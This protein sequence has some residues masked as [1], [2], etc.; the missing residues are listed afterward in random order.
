MRV[1]I[2]G[3]NFS[4]ELTGIGKYTGELA[5][6]LAQHGHE[7][8][9]ITSP[10]YYPYWSVQR[11]YRA[12][13]YKREHLDGV[14]V[15]RCPLWVPGRPTAIKRIIHLA[16]FAL[17]SL[18]V[19]LSQVTWR[20]HIVFT[21]EPTLFGVT[22]AALVAKLTGAKS[23][24]HV[25]DLEVDA[26]MGLGIV[27]GGTA[28]RVMSKSERWLMNRFDRVSSIS[29][30]MLTRLQ[31][32]GVAAD[33]L[34]EFL[35]WVDT[36]DI[37]PVDSADLLRAEWGIDKAARVVLYSGNIG[38]KQGLDVILRVAAKMARTRP[39]VLFLIVGE[40]AA[41]RELEQTAIDLKL[42]NVRFKP[43]M[44]AERLA[45]LLSLADVHLVMQRRGAADLVMPSKLAAILASGGVSLVTADKDTELYRLI[46]GS[47]LGMVV[48]AESMPS[49]MTGLE[50]LLDNGVMRR[51]FQK[52]GRHYA[53]EILDKRVILHRFQ[54]LMEKLV[55][56]TTNG[57]ITRLVE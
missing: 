4:P 22:V 28:A 36:T 46:H 39:D 32:K 50:Q 8:R 24:L 29:G 37:R 40:G 53:E 2:H 41:R 1:L 42:A 13:I 11:P 7:V 47:R 23:W 5:Q 6:W 43:L 15:Y 19:A 16:S 34:V 17:S 52:N 30:A 31:E 54:D 48:E 57:R 45:A 25:Q 55:G 27:A 56:G 51:T 10:P 35:N 21:V 26:A 20:P 44:P 14:S 33:R 12:W 38:K 9:V 49:I 18:P 3:I